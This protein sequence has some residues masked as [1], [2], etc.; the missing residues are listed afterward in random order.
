MMKLPQELLTELVAYW[1]TK[2][3]ELIAKLNTLIQDFQQNSQ[4][5]YLYFEHD[6]E[7]LA[8]FYYYENQK[9][10]LIND[11]TEFFD[12]LFPNTFFE[13]E[14]GI[15]EEANDNEEIAEA[16]DDYEYQ[17]LTQFQD[18]FADCWQQ[19]RQTQ[20]FDKRAFFS[21]HDSYFIYDLENREIVKGNT[22]QPN[23]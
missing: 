2:N 20:N 10:V 4:A 9:R 13:Q 21:T 16:W 12:G 23:D 5:Q 1:Q 14:V 17:K 3:T 7:D 11:Y 6:F 8:I 15:D 22:L 19:S 18:W